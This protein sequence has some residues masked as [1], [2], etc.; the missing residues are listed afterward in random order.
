MKLSKKEF[1]ELASIHVYG[2][3]DNKRVALFYDWL[4]NFG[5]KYMVK[6]YGCTKAQILKDGYNILIKNDCSELCWYDMKIAQTDKE[7]FKVPISG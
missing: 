4:G 5:Y 1:K 6:G 2:C 3:G 7:R